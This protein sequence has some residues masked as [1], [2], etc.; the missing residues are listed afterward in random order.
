[1]VRF[2][3]LNPTLLKWFVDN[4]ISRD[5]AVEIAQIAMRGQYKCMTPKFP[6]VPLVN[7]AVRQC[8]PMNSASKSEPQSI[9]PNK[10]EIAFLELAYNR[11]YDL[12]EEIVSQNFV[13]KK[14]AQRFLKIKNALEV[15]SELLGYQPLKWIIEHLKTARPPM[16]AELSSEL[17]KFIRNVIIHYPFFDEWDQVWINKELVSWNKENTTIEKFLIKNQQKKEVKYRFYDYKNKEMTYLKIDFDYDYS[18]GNKVFLKNIISE[19]P[20]NRFLMYLMKRTL[21]SQVET[22]G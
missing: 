4:V 14:P 9:R 1:M 22:I 20:G 15:Y 11:F 21:D 3:I 2:F 18:S 19:I 17:I 10:A 16:E 12:Y 13:D 7:G 8:E 6:R 5:K